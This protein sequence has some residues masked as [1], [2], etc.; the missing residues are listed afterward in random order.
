M[1]N[2]QKYFEK[3]HENIRTDYD[4]SST[5]RDKRDI[6]LK[7]KNGTGTINA[8]LMRGFEDVPPGYGKM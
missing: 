1:A 8:Q 4:M 5:L 3:F 2:L 6:I 7:R